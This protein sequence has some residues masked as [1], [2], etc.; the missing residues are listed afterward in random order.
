MTTNTLP[1][2]NFTREYGWNPVEANLLGASS[3]FSG[4]TPTENVLGSVNIFQI[5]HGITPQKPK[6]CSD[7]TGRVVPCDSKDAVPYDQ[8]DGVTN[9]PLAQGGNGSGSTTASPEGY[10]K[11]DI[12]VDKN[13]NIVPPNTPGA[14][15][16]DLYGKDAGVGATVKGALGIDADDLFK[17]IT[18]VV[19]GIVI[20]A[21]ALVSLR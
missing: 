19:I 7:K 5:A 21:I 11:R 15:Q 13:G 1:M 9:D 17:R 10:T 20:L 12:W 4:D 3:F 8:R 18:F 14:T 6:F 16:A 2:V